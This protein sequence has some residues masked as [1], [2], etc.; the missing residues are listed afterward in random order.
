MRRRFARRHAAFRRLLTLVLAFSL[1]LGGVMPTA[2]GAETAE[3]KKVTEVVYIPVDDR[4]F[5]DERMQLMAKSLGIRLIMPPSDLYAT[6]L[7]GQATGSSQYG[8]RSALII[9]LKAQAAQ[10]DIF[11]ISLDQLLSGGLMNSRCM[12]EMESVYVPGSGHM[13]EYDVI[14]Y[15]AEL[16][17]E[18][19]LYII[20][21]VLRLACACDYRGYTIQNYWYTRAFGMLPRFVLGGDALTVDNIIR[22]YQSNSTLGPAYAELIDKYVAIRERKLRISDYAVRALANRENVCYLLGV[23]DSSS[24][25]NIQSNEISYFEQLLGENDLIFSAVDGLGQA[26]LAKIYRNRHPMGTFLVSVDYYGSDPENIGEYN[27]LSTE[28]MLRQEIAYY[29]GTIV[30]GRP[31]VSVLVV[32]APEDATERSNVFLNAIDRINRNEADQIPTILID[33][34][35]NDQA[36]FHQML[37]S[38]VHLGTLLAYSGYYERPVQATM[39]LSQGLARYR[40][41]WVGTSVQ[42]NI[43]HL[44]NLLGAYVKEVYQT[45]DVRKEISEY[46]TEK[47]LDSSNFGALWSGSQRMLERDLTIKLQGATTAL[48]ENFAASNVILS[49]PGYQTGAITQAKLGNCSYPWLRGFEIDCE[50]DC[51]YQNTPYEYEYI[52]AYLSGKE[53]GTFDPEGCLTRNQAAKM[54]IG[55]SGEPLVKGQVNPFVDVPDWAED[56]VLTAYY[57]SYIKGYGDDRFQGDRTMTRAEFAAL[58]A[59]YVEQNE[60]ELETVQEANFA[61]LPRDSEAWYTGNL[62]LLAD[63]GLL[64]RNSGFIYPEDPVTRAEA[65][66][67]LCELF[68][69]LEDMP[70]WLQSGPRF[71]D[72]LPGD[73]AYSAIQEASVSRFV[74]KE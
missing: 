13:T 65:A 50:T 54:L 58:L 22:Y 11:V 48:M 31:E 25:N 39:A 49:M 69:R 21:S 47:K 56:Y 72:V 64:T 62:Y 68:Q 9:W 17:Q 57:R 40:S 42:E 24:G 37:C 43:S 53:D 34:S 59:Q 70:G 41:L 6:K 61:D 1:G 5:H 15:L 38:S 63:A 36:E 60:M 28:T 44:N 12:E 3:K 23:D 55:A 46:W 16:S 73:W 45:G 14:D 29:G 71:S 20:D 67:I 26:A 19:E 7:D 32:S 2:Y 52:G 74:Q 51:G 4:P 27:F 10:H 30:T 35:E 66:S 8:N 18:K 33:L